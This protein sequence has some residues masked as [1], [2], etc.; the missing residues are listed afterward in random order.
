MKNWIVD[1]FVEQMKS[2]REE[3]RYT[4]RQRNHLMGGRYSLLCG[5]GTVLEPDGSI[6]DQGEYV[7]NALTNTGQSDILNVY[8]RGTSAT[9][10]F[11][12]RLATASTGASAPAKTNA[13]ADIV[14]SGAS[15]TQ[16][17]ESAGGGYASQSLANANWGV[18]GL[19]SGDEQSAAAQKTFGPASG[20]AWTGSSGTTAALTYAFLSTATSGTSG[21]L[22]CYI[23]LSG[24][25]T[26]NIGQSF[27]YTLS[28]KQT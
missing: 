11:Y 10:T 12:L 27:L 14:T 18:P 16:I 13:S 8:L 26:I 19:A 9:A 6:A 24:T 7:P 5:M 1:A 28:F 21:T 3:R 2:A 25:T 20:A 23:A 17:Q 4:A 15:S 22:V